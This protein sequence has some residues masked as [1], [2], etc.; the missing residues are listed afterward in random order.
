MVRL[1]GTSDRPRAADGATCEPPEVHERNLWLGARVIA[2]TTIMFFA[3]FVFAYFYLRSL[4]NSDL[5]RPAGVDPPQRYGIAIVLLFVLS[6][7]LLA[8]AAWAAREK[9]GW[10]AAAGTALALGLAGCVVQVFEYANLHFS[11]TDGGYASVFIGWTALFVVFVLLTMYWVEILF[12]EGVRNR[13]AEAATVPAGLADAALLLGP[14][15]GHRGAQPGRSS[16]CSEPCPRRRCPSSW[17][18]DPALLWVIL[19]AWL[20]WL[21]G[22]GVRPQPS[23]ARRWRTGRLHRR[24]RDRSSWPSP[25]RSTTGP[26]SSSG[27]TCSS[28]CSCCSSPL[29]CWRWPGHGTGCGGDSRS[30]FADGWRTRSPGAAGRPACGGRR[31]S[32]AI[33][34]PPGCCSRSPS[35]SGTSR[36]RTTRPCARRWFTRTS[37]RSSSRTGLLFWTRV[38]DSPPWRSPLAEGARAVYVASAMV[39]SW[40]LAIVLAFATLAPVRPLRGGGDPTRRDQRAH[41]PAARRRGDVGARLDPVHDCNHLHH[42]PLAGARAC[43]RPGSPRPRARR[44]P[45]T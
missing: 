34:S 30:A 29:R 32:S 19:A 39:V 37:T 28:T 36:S 3:A 2:G 14:A 31:G 13:G 42:L 33:R 4:N 6:A 23:A 44:K 12:A 41:G 15:G 22:R 16:T 25:R 9:R 40:L 38:I 11:P 5:W 26:K 7:G 24:A 18:T 27:R 45:V 17:T 43:A 1:P 20:Y 35:A 21:G 8:Y 10:L